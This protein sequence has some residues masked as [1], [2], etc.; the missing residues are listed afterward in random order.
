MV[1]QEPG[2]ALDP[3]FTVGYQISEAIRARTPA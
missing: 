1:F 3:P 2:A